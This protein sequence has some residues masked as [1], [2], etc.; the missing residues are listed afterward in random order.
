MVTSIG[1]GRGGRSSE[2]G[3][4]Q[5]PWLCV[6]QPANEGC[7]AAPI[8]TWIGQGRG[9]LELGRI[10]RLDYAL[11]S[12]PRRRRSTDNLYDWDLIGGRGAGE[13][14]SSAAEEALAMR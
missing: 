2:A 13:C 8:F 6:V 12:L 4:H 3:P 11:R 1:L 10:D 5:P 14:C 7:A 9:M